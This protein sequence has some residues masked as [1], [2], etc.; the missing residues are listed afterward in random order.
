MSGASIAVAPGLADNPRDALM[1]EAYFDV[2]MLLTPKTV[3]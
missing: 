2:I 1:R 3:S